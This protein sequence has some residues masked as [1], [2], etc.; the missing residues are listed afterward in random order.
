[1]E[2]RACPEGMSA[3]QFE[4]AQRV[5]Q[6]TEKA[7]QEEAWKMACLLAGKED[8]K[9]FGQSEFQLRD[10][11]HRIGAITLEA[12]VNERRKKRATSVVALP[13]RASTTASPAATSAPFISASPPAGTPSGKPHSTER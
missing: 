9:M 12:A 4:F 13:A 5:L 1:M 10:H 2:G 7:R 3:E 8:G 11:I 6:V